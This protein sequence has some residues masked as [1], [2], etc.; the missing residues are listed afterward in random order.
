VFYRDFVE[1]GALW[2]REHFIELLDKLR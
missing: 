1:K 2:E